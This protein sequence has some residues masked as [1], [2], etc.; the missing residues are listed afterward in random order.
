MTN[1]IRMEVIQK[2]HKD[3]KNIDK[4]CTVHEVSDGELVQQKGGLSGTG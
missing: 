3:F 1:E 4:V 2:N